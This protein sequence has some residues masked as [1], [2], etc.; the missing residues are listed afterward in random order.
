MSFTISQVIATMASY[1]SL[2]IVDPS[3]SRDKTVEATYEVVQL[4]SL[5]N[6][7]ARVLYSIQIGDSQKY[8]DFFEFIYSG[9]GNPLEE[10]E[11]ALKT[12]L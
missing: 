8:Y 2:G 11:V 12:S 4:D 1:P 10:A 5:L 9:K 6:S 3:T 7:T